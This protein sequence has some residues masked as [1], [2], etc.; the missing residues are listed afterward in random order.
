MLKSLPLHCLFFFYYHAYTFLVK[1]SKSLSEL[2]AK[3]VRKKMK[4]KAFARTVNREDIRQGAEELGV[5]VETHIEF[6]IQ[7]MQAKAPELG[8]AGS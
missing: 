4:D 5:P 2:D 7:A 3:S 8:L 1:P 6:C